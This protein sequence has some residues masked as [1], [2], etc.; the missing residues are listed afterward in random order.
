MLEFLQK[1]H[2]LSFMLPKPKSKIVNAA[3]YLAPF[4]ENCL[5]M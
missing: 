4:V 2:K 5:L 1:A 3:K